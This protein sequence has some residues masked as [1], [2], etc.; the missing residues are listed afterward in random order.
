MRCK[1][2]WI[3]FALDGVPAHMMSTAS[4]PNTRIGK[5]RMNAIRLAASK[6]SGPLYAMS[7]GRTMLKVSA[8]S[9]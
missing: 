4:P 9:R 1:L 7:Q 6:I 5:Q 8:A 3:L 2:F